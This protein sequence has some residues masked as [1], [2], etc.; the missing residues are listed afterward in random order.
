MPRSP[1]SADVWRRAASTSA[2]WQAIAPVRRIW[3]SAETALS[4]VTR[5][6]DSESAGR[7]TCQD[8]RTLEILE[9]S[10]IFQAADR[11]L[12]TA[13]VAWRE[14]RAGALSEWL[15]GRLRP[16]SFGGRARMAGGMIAVAS[17]TALGL[18]RLAS[19]SAPLTWIVPAVFLVVGL[20]LIGM[21]TERSSR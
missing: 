3:M 21:G 7:S 11:T 13:S 20:C 14:S 10:R 1:Q 19:R 5:G 16:R 8:E 15:L 17:A 18:Q 9:S 4:R 2:I 6:F 12:A